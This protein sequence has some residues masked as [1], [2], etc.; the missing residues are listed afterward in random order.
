MHALTVLNMLMGGINTVSAHGTGDPATYMALL[1][2]V[3]LDCI[4]TTTVSTAVITT[5]IT[6]ITTSITVI[7]TTTASTVVIPEPLPT[8]YT[9]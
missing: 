6:V 7:T 4:T 2:P 1:F 5:N 3:V 9:E 8:T